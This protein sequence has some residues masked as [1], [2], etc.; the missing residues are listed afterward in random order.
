MNLIQTKAIEGVKETYKDVLNSAYI[1][2]S[3]GI[4]TYT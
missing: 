1:E 4:Y 3:S 2:T